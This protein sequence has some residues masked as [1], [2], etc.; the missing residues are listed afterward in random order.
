MAGSEGCLLSFTGL[1]RTDVYVSR[2]ELP[3]RQSVHSPE[4]LHISTMVSGGTAL[5]ADV[6]SHSPV[7][8]PTLEEVVDGSSPSTIP[9][10]REDAARPRLV[11]PVRSAAARKMWEGRGQ[12]ERSAITK[13]RLETWGPE[14][15]V[16]SSKKAKQTLGPE[17]RRAVAK[18]AKDTLGPEGRQAVTKKAKETLGLEGRRMAARK[19]KETMGAEA[20]QEAARKGRETM[21]PERRSAAA[22]KAKE[23]MGPEARRAASEKRF[24]KWGPEARRESSKKAKQ[25]LGPEGRRAVAKK[26]KDT[27]GPDGRSAVTKKGRETLGPEGCR[28]VARKGK[29]TMGPDGRKAITQKAMKTKGPDGLRA[30]SLKAA[31]TFRT[32]GPE[33]MSTMLQKRAVTAGLGE[34]KR[35]M[36]EACSVLDWWRRDIAR[37]TTAGQ[38]GE[39]IRVCRRC[40]G[41]ME[42][43]RLTRKLRKEHYCLAELDTILDELSFVWVEEIW[44]CRVPGSCSLKKPDKLYLALAMVRGQEVPWYLQVEIDEGWFPSPVA[45]GPNRE[46]KG[47]GHPEKSCED[48]DMRLELI[49]SDVLE[50][51]GATGFVLRIAPDN[52]DAP[53]FASSRQGGACEDGL[54]ATSHF[55]AAF[56]ALRESLPRVV[57]TL[58]AGGVRRL[59]FDASMASP[60]EVTAAPE[61]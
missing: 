11:C 16:E 8:T 20:R 15:R 52:P 61:L 40:L 36:S 1:E 58:G 46:L 29:E 48:E 35:C 14:E 22:C 44:D 45:V 38:E 39:Q 53:M 4:S 51:Y 42:P 59:F 32:L 18:K 9:L 41:H 31:E 33:R 5:S 57:S 56:A 24:E 43:E 50:A 55:H 34:D 17:G 23:T 25:T 60:T 27:L 26:A 28:E 54:R 37:H 47:R 3:P 7:L 30:A 10:P 19:G 12:E 2:E 21:G 6:S 13:K 49:A